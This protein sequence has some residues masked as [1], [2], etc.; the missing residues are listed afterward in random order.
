MG[1]DSTFWLYLG[2]RK[3][4]LS[5]MGMELADSTSHGELKPLLE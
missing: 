5:V 2:I 1:Y 3:A 4:V